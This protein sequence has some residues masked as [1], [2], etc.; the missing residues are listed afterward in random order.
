M[1]VPARGAGLARLASLVAYLGA[2]LAIL[3]G[4]VLAVSS[5]GATGLAALGM[6]AGAF[7]IVAGVIALVPAK[8]LGTAA[9]VLESGDADQAEPHGRTRRLSTVV[10]IGAAAAYIAPVAILTQTA[11]L[12]PVVLLLHLVTGFVFVAA[13]WTARQLGRRPLAIGLIAIALL[14]AALPAMEAVSFAGDWARRQELV[15]QQEAFDALYAPIRNGPS[16]A[17]AGEVIGTVGSW[18]PVMGGV[19]PNVHTDSWPEDANDLFLELT[20][21]TVRFTIVGQCWLDGIAGAMT[22]EAWFA[23]TRDPNGDVR[24]INLDIDPVP[25]DGELHAITSAAVGVP[26]WFDTSGHPADR[27]EWMLASAYA[28]AANPA[29]G[30]SIERA[31]RWLMFVSPE[32]ASSI[33]ELVA[34]V[35]AVFDPIRL[36]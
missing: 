22:V 16:A 35:A 27:Y 3:A 33:D 9:G 17:R 1:P 34:A 8:L 25:C 18:R 24:K 13:A 12:D 10:A 6:L 15:A 36:R 14:G 31:E 20:G 28:S 4:G 5:I 11:G 21:R 7:L 2:G 26:T 19:W 30:A 29:P 32:P 23:Q